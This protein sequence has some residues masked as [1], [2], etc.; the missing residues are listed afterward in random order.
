MS[1]RRLSTVSAVLAIVALVGILW[2]M[3]EHV[4]AAGPWPD[5]YCLAPGNAAG[6]VFGPGPDDVY[7][8]VSPCPSAVS[9]PAPQPIRVVEDHVASP[10]YAPLLAARSIDL[11]ERICSGV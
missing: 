4:S 6:D 2:L 7:P 3:G 9:A 1:A 5:D 10:T 11:L 8:D